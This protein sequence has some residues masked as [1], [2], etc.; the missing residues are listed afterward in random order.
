[1][2]A[3]IVLRVIGHLLFWGWNL[4]FFALL[5]F[6]MGP[7]VLWEIVKA[8]WVGLIPADFFVTSALLT[9]IPAAGL[10]LGLWKLRRD[11]GRLLTLF[12]GIQ[13]PL[14]LAC[15][16]RLFAIRQLTWSTTAA[17]I[18]FAVGAAALLRTVL[19]GPSASRG[20]LQLLHQLG[21]TVYGMV[22]LWALAAVG[23]LILPMGL[24][25]LW[26]LSHIRHPIDLLFTAFAFA[27]ALLMLLFPVA[28]LGSSLRAW[29]LVNRATSA[30]FGRPVSATLAL[31]TAGAVLAVF[32][33]GTSQPQLRAW[34]LLEPEEGPVQRELALAE[35]ETIREGLLEAYLARQRYPVEAGDMDDAAEHVWEDTGLA[36]LGG[37]MGALVE[38]AWTPFAYRAVTGRIGDEGPTR[39]TSNLMDDKQWA[40]QAWL[41]FFDTPITRAEQETILAAQSSTWNWRTA[42]ASLI[43]VGRQQVWLE[44]QEIDL[45]EHGDHA[46]ITVH[47]VYRNVTWDRREV[48]VYFSLP[49]TAAVSGLWLGTSPDRAEAF[50][51]VV[52]PRGAAQQVYREEVQFRR[53]PA[54]L[55][56][57]G[58][59]QYRLRAFPIE[60]REGDVDVGRVTELGPEM[61][62]WMELSVLATVTEQGPVWPMPQVAE[63][64]NLY[65][66]DDSDRSGPDDAWLPTSLP[67]TG[68]LPR[69][70][71]IGVAGH[72]VQLSP[73]EPKHATLPS[74]T[75]VVIDTTRSMEG[76]RAQL[77]AALTQLAGHPVLCAG[78]DGVASC[79]PETI[80]F[81]G[82]AS[83]LEILGQLEDHPVAAQAETIVLLTD[84]STYDQALDRAE[85]LTLPQLVLVHLDG[86]PLAYADVVQDA[87][88]AIG[89]TV[90]QALTRLAG[91]LSTGWQVTVQPGDGPPAEGELDAIAARL[92]IET[93]SRQ[94]DTTDLE[95][96][97]QLHRLAM[98]HDVVSPFSSMLVLVDD[99]QRERLAELEKDQDRFAREA[100]SAATEAGLEPETISSVPEPEEWM[101]MITLALM[102]GAGVWR[103]GRLGVAARA[104]QSVGG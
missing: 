68:A 104:P 77:A 66:D 47:D 51:H 63:V 33:A 88:P 4:L 98:E 43:D 58:P 24:H 94:A 21:Q 82:R 69:A 40:E 25:L 87:R 89:A 2:I 6:G 61:H 86:L 34:E 32:A 36:L 100:E 90:D 55:E 70:H 99:R 38:L 73:A 35:S 71:T 31:I 92:A 85:A 1:M 39:W 42:E 5:G 29:L 64:R 103:R 3:R 23:P 41:R 14:M 54:L 102:L 15:V 60:P 50:E 53:D 26:G 30:R 22:A 44:R 91:S 76:Q 81:W 46:T 49:E 37:P 96:L 8:V 67:A 97:D 27:T 62:L 95:V 9:L 84:A 79:D 52:A 11:P 59:R 18:L 65:W 20:G 57:V 78:G 7:V 10:V 45:E 101:L 83:L 16:L 13:A 80:Q 19:V 56:Q 74:G 75:V 48:V 93:L 72:V 12:Y 17:L 28:M